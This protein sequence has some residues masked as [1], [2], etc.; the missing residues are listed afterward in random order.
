MSRSSRPGRPETSQP[1][2]LAEKNKEAKKEAKK[3]GKHS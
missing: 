3:G 1:Q 2:L